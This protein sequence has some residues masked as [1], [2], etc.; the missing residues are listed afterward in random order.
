MDSE[1]LPT[2]IEHKLIQSLK[3]WV[4]G[5][6][7]GD[8][9]AVLPGQTLIT[10]DTLVE[11]TH[12][13]LG[14]TSLADLAW[15]A[16]AVNLSDIAA[17]AGKPRYAMVSLTIPPYFQMRQFKELYCSLV[18]CARSFRTEIVGGDLTAGPILILAITII[19][20]THEVGCLTRSA[21][22]PGDLVAVT[23]DF[24]ASAAGLWALGS[25][26]AKFSYVKERHCR[27][28]PRLNESWAL[29]KSTNG[30]GALM[31]AS[32]GLADALVQISQASAV[33][34]E[35]ELDLVPV[36]EQTKAVALLA[37]VELSDWLLFGGE[38]YELV[39][40]LDEKDF[41]T[42]SKS[43]DYCFTAIGRVTKS[44]GV[45]VSKAGRPYPP[46]DLGRSFQHWEQK[47]DHE[48]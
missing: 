6:Y 15:K 39:F 9:C 14:S 43:V 29:V 4:G 3:T 8:D 46:L 30:Q 24:G 7:I 12:F 34:M 40:C 32:D 45:N 28:Q 25:G 16:I 23:G 44:K 10:A 41:S 1:Y 31:D 27:P 20:E 21:A 38:D 2:T 22:K 13:L 35:I 11:G 17:M 5:T 18:E 36:H 33:G 42:L 48:R 26:L 19:G 37:Q 47:D